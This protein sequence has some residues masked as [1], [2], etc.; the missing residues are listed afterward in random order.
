MYPTLL[1]FLPMSMPERKKK[2]KKTKHRLKIVL[3]ERMLFYKHCPG[4]GVGCLEEHR[5]LIRFYFL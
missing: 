4:T 2:N 3:R 5:E 1:L